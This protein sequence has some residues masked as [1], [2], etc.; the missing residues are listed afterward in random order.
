MSLLSS[1]G[2]DI[3]SGSGTVGGIADIGLSAIPGVGD[4][5]G[6]VQT[7]KSVAATNEAN[8]Q[9]ARE[10]MAFQERMSSTAHQREVSDLKAAGLNPILSAGSGESS[11]S[12]AMPDLTPVPSVVASAAHSSR[13][14]LQFMKDMKE[15]DSRIALNKQAKETSDADG[16]LKTAQANLTNANIPAAQNEAWKSSNDQWIERKFPRLFSVIDAIASRG[17][18]ANSALGVGSNLKYLIKK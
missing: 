7:A 18:G 16:K 12:G 10:Q 15:A 17:A 1:I 11:P 2:S 5:L 13:D 8:T 4:Y 3:V 14:V 9:N 6:A